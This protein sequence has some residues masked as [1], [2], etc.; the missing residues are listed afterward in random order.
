MKRTISIF[1]YPVVLIEIGGELT[2]TC[3]DLGIY[4]VV[5]LPE[6]KKVGTSAAVQISYSW[7]TLMRQIHK[8]IQRKIAAGKPLPIPSSTKS[9]F[10]M[11]AVEKKTLSPKEL[12]QLCNVGENT[13][14]RAI[15][16]KLIRDVE[17]TPG[18]HR[19]IPEHS[20]AEFR[21]SLS[22]KVSD[23]DTQ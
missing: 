5:R 2:W 17:I 16:K 10:D 22:Q 21:A 9:L 23:Q 3:P 14:R 1:S 12:A 13:V 11:T 4:K 19:K 18:G 20:A 15:D 8:E 6:G 7:L